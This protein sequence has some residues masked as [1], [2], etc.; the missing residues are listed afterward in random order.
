MKPDQ[1]LS[2]AIKQP[3]QIY[4]VLI[5][6]D[7]G[8]ANAGSP[9]EQITKDANTLQEI[10]SATG[11]HDYLSPNSQ[12]GVDSIA[13]EVARA[14]KTQ[15]LIG[16]KSTNTAM[17]GKRRGVKVKLNLPEGSPKLKAWTKSAYYA[18]KEKPPKPS[19]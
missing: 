10:T 16:Y 7:W 1:L 14:L 4:T 19:N 8:T 18:A 2:F 11:G 9:C 5:A 3:V 6:D 12:G 13:T 15:Y 17:N